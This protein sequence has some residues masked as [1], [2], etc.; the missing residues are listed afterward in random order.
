MLQIACK[1]V[2][3]MKW[4]ALGLGCFVAIQFSTFVQPPLCGAEDAGRVEKRFE[5]PTQPKATLE[6]KIEVPPVT[7]EKLPAGAEKKLFTLSGVVVEGATIYADTDFLPLYEKYLGKTV[8]LADVYKIAE[9]ITAKYRN[10][11]YILSKAFVPPQTIQ[12]GIVRILV[13]EGFVDKVIIEGDVK[14]RQSLLDA[15]SS[16]IIASRPLRVKDLERYLL[17]ADDLPGVTVKSVFKPSADQVGASTL[18]IILDHKSFDGSLS[19]DNRGTDNVGPYQGVA[20]V[21]LNSILGLY[22]NTS[23]RFAG[24]TEIRELQYYQFTH[25]ETL[26]SEGLTLGFTGSFSRSEPGGTLEDD[27]VKSESLSLTLQ[28]AYPIIRLHNKNFSVYLGFTYRNARTDLL[29]SKLSEDRLR[30]VRAGLN[31]DLADR[32]QGVSLL[33][34]EISQGLNILDETP[35]GSADLT[36]AEGH[37]DFTKL[38]ASLSRTQQ[39][40]KRFALTASATGQ[41]AGHKLLSSE[42]LGVGGSDFG[43]AYDPSEITGDRGFA[44]LLELRHTSKSDKLG[45]QTIQPFIFCDYGQVHQIGTGHDVLAS[46]G[47]GLRLGTKHFSASIEIAKPLVHDVAAKGNK[48]PRV[49]FSLKGVF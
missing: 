12:N 29:G 23:I 45:L 13:V 6:K 24:T 16:K 7:E 10:A 47:G 14:G 5:K 35:T 28:T 21:G 1:L 40:P 48:D 34:F 27:E 11:G 44:A 37:S 25:T 18:T 26:N 8:S 20:G 38:T 41:W 32:F 19:F 3:K 42:E 9:A 17:L 15:Y 31:F 30:I 46:A 4:F 22:E 39:L 36:R 49:F 43:R 33:S 2:S